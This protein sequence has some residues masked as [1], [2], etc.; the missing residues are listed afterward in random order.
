[1]WIL[2]SLRVGLF[3]ALCGCASDATIRSA[4]P[5]VTYN[6]SKD[7]APLV[8]CLIPSLGA[9]YSKSAVSKFR[10]VG[11][12]IVPDT[13]YDLVPTDAFVNGHYTYSV[14]VKNLGGGNVQVAL[15]QGQMMVGNI[16]ND[17][18]AAIVSCL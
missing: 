18:K 16:T 3:L 7:V 2:N 5:L 13:E 4:P 10:F 14:N 9:G 11:Q 8:A 1:M 6:S 12:V 17:I 15:Y